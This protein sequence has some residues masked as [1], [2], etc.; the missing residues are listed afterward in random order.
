MLANIATESATVLIA[1]LSL[2]SPKSEG[3]AV[4]VFLTVMNEKVDV[5]TFDVWTI[6]D[7][8]ASVVVI[9]LVCVTTFGVDVGTG[10]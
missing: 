10:R 1:L 5:V 9:K 8:A 2:F 7:P 3:N 4:C 6:V